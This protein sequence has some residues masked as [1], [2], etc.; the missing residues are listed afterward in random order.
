MHLPR[1]SITFDHGRAPLATVRYTVDCGSKIMP[2]RFFEL[3]DIWLASQTGA[4]AIDLLGGQPSDLLFPHVR[5]YL[6]PTM[7]AIGA[8]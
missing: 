5:S 6:F 2:E 4:T 7:S 1:G 3:D 8:C